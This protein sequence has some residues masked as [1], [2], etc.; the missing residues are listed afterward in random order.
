M[1]EGRREL[2][3]SQGMGDLWDQDEGFRF[4]SQSKEK[5][6]EELTHGHGGIFFILNKCFC[7]K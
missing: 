5:A 7:L 6:Q 4:K 2:A 1:G 3:G